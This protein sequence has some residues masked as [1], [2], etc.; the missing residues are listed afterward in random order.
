MSADAKYHER[1]E[2]LQAQSEANDTA[3]LAPLYAKSIALTTQTWAAL[4]RLFDTVESRSSRDSDFVRERDRLAER[5]ARARREEYARA[6]AV[7]RDPD[8]SETERNVAR[9]TLAFNRISES[10]GGISQLNTD[11]YA[12]EGEGYRQAAVALADQLVEKIY[13]P[14]ASRFSL[15]AVVDGIDLALG[16]IP[17]A[18]TIYAGLKT[19]YNMS[20]R[21]EKEARGAISYVKYLEEYC[22]AS[23]LWCLAAEALIRSLDAS[24]GD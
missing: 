10:T 13:T 9:S 12:A 15:A 8:S 1:L 14:D 19:L 17:V 2:S 21:R 16:L 24:Q 6:E 20:I 4:K 7:L 23:Q 18:G 11:I 22:H 5:K 3:T